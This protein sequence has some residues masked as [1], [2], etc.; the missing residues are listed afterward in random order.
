VITLSGF[1]ISARVDRGHLILEDGIAADRRRC[2]LPRVDHGLERLVIIGSDGQVSLAALRWLADQN[3]AFTMLDRD[4]S[5]L[6]MTGPVRSHDA[7]LRRAQAMALHNGAAFRLSR[8]IIDRKLTG[9]ER[10]ALKYFEDDAT[11][12]TIRQ[13][14]SQLAEVQSIDEIRFVEKHAAK[15]YWS[16]WR[17][18]SVWFPRKDLV[19]VPEHWRSFGSR[20]SPVS[21]STRLAS[22][23]VNAMLNYL[24][25]ILESE[26]SLAAAILGLD[27]SLGILHVD[28]LYRDSLACDLMEPIRPDVDAFVLDWIRRE[29]LSRS[30]FFEQSNGNCRLMDSLASRL[31]QTAPTW[32]RLVAPLTE[33]FAQELHK[34]PR[35]GYT[36]LATRLTGSHRRKAQGT[37][38]TPRPTRAPHPDR[39]CRNCGKEIRR[40]SRHCKNCGDD[41]NAERMAGVARLGRLAAQNTDARAKRAATQKINMKARLE[42]QQAD[43]PVWFTEAFYLQRVQP[44]LA[45]VSASEIARTLNVSR[46]YANNLRKGR[47]PHPRHWKLLVEL[48]G[49][50]ETS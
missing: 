36:N 41:L 16:A 27:P 45:A 3:A 24:Y 20:V 17:S 43:Q 49:S 18:L 8:E 40:E 23:P 14:R 9:Q 47:L 42:W 21:K 32:A 48:T 30:S 37:S 50:R 7:R 35:P 44:C 26:T 22:N 1:G 34:V 25:A 39:I 6:V 2:R 11:A 31:A 15:A 10:V 12:L 33:W 19:R 5:V 28:A 13:Y 46:S 4:G 29:P 38:P